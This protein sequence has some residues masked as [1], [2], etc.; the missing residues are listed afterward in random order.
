[1]SEMATAPPY[2]RKSGTIHVS[3]MITSIE[4]VTPAVVVPCTVIPSPG[5]SISPVRPGVHAGL[6]L[7]SGHFAVESTTSP[8]ALLEVL[9]THTTSV[10][11]RP[12]AVTS[13]TAHSYPALHTQSGL[14]NVAG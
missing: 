4:T 9:C 10:E 8:L 6:V 12:F 3:R 2:S 7:L 1:M 11:P 13:W 14:A 5:L